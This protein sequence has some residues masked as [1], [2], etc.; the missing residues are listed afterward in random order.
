MGALR[1]VVVHPFGATTVRGASFL[2][3]Q[4]L[5]WDL[6]QKGAAL[7]ADVIY[8]ELVGQV[9]EQRGDL[10]R[11]ARTKVDAQQRGDDG[12]YEADEEDDAMAPPHGADDQ[13][14]NSDSGEG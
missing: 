8:F 12:E 7:G 4:R 13:P 5:P 6:A 9:L 14:D 1:L 10:G 11:L 2:F 3:G